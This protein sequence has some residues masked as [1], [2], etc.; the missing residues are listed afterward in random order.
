V[1]VANPRIVEA[2]ERVRA[3]AKRRGVRWTTQ[4]Q[5]IVEQFLLAG[6]HLTAD[7]LHARARDVDGAIGAATVYRTL[8]LLV[9]IG[10]AARVRLGGGSASFEPVLG[11]AHHDH[12]ICLACG[13]VVEFEDATIERRQSAIAAQHGYAL[14]HHRLELFGLCPACQKRLAAETP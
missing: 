11:R 14:R 12:L 6:E 2:Q 7:E 3:E 1:P 9:D 13:A 10:V 8:N 4:R 5:V